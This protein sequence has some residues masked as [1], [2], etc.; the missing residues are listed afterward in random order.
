MCL[1]PLEIFISAATEVKH[2]IIIL[3]QDGIDAET[4]G[5]VEEKLK[6][7]ICKTVTTVPLTDD[8]TKTE[9]ESV[10]SQKKY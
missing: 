7:V 3:L 5:A 10:S 9:N 2:S 4:A 1:G 6:E 8:S